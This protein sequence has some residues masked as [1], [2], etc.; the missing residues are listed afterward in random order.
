M[1]LFP[2]IDLKDGQV[3]RLT[4]GDYGSAERYGGTPVGFAQSYEADGASCLHV[5]DLDGAKDGTLANF[6]VVQSIIENCGL[7]VEVGGGIRNADRVRQYLQLGVGRVI[8]GTAALE[9]PKFLKSMVAQYGDKIAVGVDARDGKVATG[10]WLH[11]SST[12]GVEFCRQLKE[13]GVS[14]VIYTD[15]SRDGAMKG[16]N[17]SIYETLC[18]IGGIDIVASGGISSEEEITAL[19]TIGCS[20]AIIGKALY[21]KRLSLKRLL[22]LAEGE[23][24]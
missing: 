24:A 2:A 21:E 17:L 7:F 5:V 1:K 16:T 18:A 12:D 13:D 19:R 4:M 14:T 8:L 20:G 3:V 15:I 22:L 9:D 10:G 6:P 23:Q 11:T